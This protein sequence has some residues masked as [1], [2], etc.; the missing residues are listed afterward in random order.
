[1][2]KNKNRQALLVAIPFVLAILIMLPRLL[3]PQFGLLDDA[4]TL[5][6]ARNFLGGDF[7]MSHDFQAG[8]FRPIYWLYYTIIY[9]FAGYHSFWYFISN[10]VILFIL[11][12]EIR[13]LLKRSGAAEWQILLTSCIFLFS[14]PI[15][16]NFYTLSKGEPLQLTLIISAIL[17]LTPKF[18]HEEKLPWAKGI[19]AA[20]LLLL[21]IMVKETAIVMLPLIVF[22]ALYVTYFRKN[23]NL[24]LYRKNYWMLVGSVTIAVLA[25]F[26]L[27]QS[28]QST[29]LLEGTYTDRYLIDLGET[30]N[31][32][33]RW[34][35]QYAYYFHY[36]MPITLFWVWF[37]IKKI[38]INQNQKF[39]L[40]RWATW[41]FFWF[42]V[43]IPWT[44]AE[45]YYLLPFAFGGAMLIGLTAPVFLNTL[46][47]SKASGRTVPLILGIL[48]SLLFLLTL[49][50]YRTEAKMQLAFDQANNEMLTY[51]TETAP[52]NSTVLMNLRTSNEYS[53]KFDIY[54]KEHYQR[55]DISFGVLDSTQMETV[56]TQSCVIALMPYIE[57]QPTLTVR[58]GIE[59]T[60]QDR[61]N[62]TFLM[63][64]E[65]NRQQLSVFEESFRLSNINLPIIL[66]NFGLD[67]GFCQNPDPLFDYRAFTYGWEISKIQ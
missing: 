21:A 44:Y 11:L 38:S 22:W 64:T 18:V 7:S 45:S 41:W 32:L 67:A 3:S 43:F 63:T 50:N 10:L 6:Q 59:E 48:A 34:V 51:L 13:L 8:R 29:G 39:M 62:E 28:I 5:Q 4:T 42:V 36:T 27:R 40:F 33:L 60:Y 57:N 17:V 9:F 15:I 23:K 26:G 30:L 66:C 53:E 65:E 16:G 58:A 54:L 49:P 25:Y 46:K 56:N 47:R 20:S 37:V 35:T 61:W 55:T 14:M 2:A 52:E 24:K 12:V 31:K 1:M 19:F